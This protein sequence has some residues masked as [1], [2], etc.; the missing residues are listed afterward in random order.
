MFEKHLTL[1]RISALEKFQ[2]QNQNQIWLIITL[3]K[4]KFFHNSIFIYASHSLQIRFSGSL[5]SHVLKTILSYITSVS[6]QFSTKM[7]DSDKKYVPLEVAIFQYINSKT[8]RL[9]W[10]TE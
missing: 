6:C 8:P 10:S 2:R 4:I 7:H 3:E 5:W 9:M 1:C